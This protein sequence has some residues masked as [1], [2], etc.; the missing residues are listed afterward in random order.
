MNGGIFMSLAS[1]DEKL[2]TFYI[3]ETFDNNLVYIDARDMKIP[4]FDAAL[5]AESNK[6]CFMLLR[7]L[8]DE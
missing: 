5:R 3:L 1:M 6:L 2:F 4:S 7:L 8:N